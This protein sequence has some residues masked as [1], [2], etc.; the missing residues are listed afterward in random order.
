MILFRDDHHT[1]QEAVSS[2]VTG[3]GK[4]LQNGVTGRIMVV[5]LPSPKDVPVS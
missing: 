3:V 5:N 4:L 2:L 1:I